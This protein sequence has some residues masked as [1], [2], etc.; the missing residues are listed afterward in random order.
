MP[1][2]VTRYNLLIS[3][4]SDV[5][6][7]IKIIR[8]TI[9]EYNKRDGDKNNTVI[10]T[11][12][13]SKDSYPQSGGRPQ[14]LLNQQFVL[15][16]DFVVAVFWTRFGTPTEKYGSGTEEE[17]EE[18]LKSGKQ[19][20]LYFSDQALSP[21]SYDPSQYRKVEKFR[22]KY[23]GRGIYATYKTLQEFEKQF[24]DH[25]KQYF[26]S[27]PHEKQ[28]IPM[29]AQ[30]Q[31]SIQG[32]NK[33]KPADQIKL[34][35]YDLLSL[36]FIEQAKE[37]IVSEFQKIKNIQLPV[38]TTKP[39]YQEPVVISERNKSLLC[40]YANKNNIE[41]NPDEFFYLGNLSEFENLGTFSLIGNV[42]EK[43]K[44]RRIH[45]LLTAI[46]KNQ[47]FINFFTK[48]DSKHFLSLCLSNHGTHPDE[49]IE[50]RLFVDKG[51]LC[52]KEE[53]PFPGIG[54]KNAMG[55][56]D[57]DEL[58]KNVY[59]EGKSL[60][61]KEYESENVNPTLLDD[62]F[63]YAVGKMM[64]TDSE[65]AE[66]H[67]K[68]YIEEINDI[69]IYDY[70]NEDS[71]DILIYTQNYIKH[72]TNIYLPSKLVF[73]SPP[74]NIRYEIRSKHSPNVITGEIKIEI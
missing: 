7:E 53:L 55:F 58:L 60:W 16:C 44:F 46:E 50:V 14:E 22:K 61:V 35:Q 72:N 37:D 43:A 38:Q 5:K 36:K 64:P 41:L 70:Y 66:I 68:N 65:E 30:A 57:M 74:D 6:D 34:Y 15:N 27:L 20:F 13:W 4:P 62:E 51:L 48:M 67:R 42:E 71:M 18:L 33:G 52:K 40:D 73:N 26:D 56:D 54:M 11:K 28:V 25:L 19:V 8:E 69:F 23:E 49:E 3:C 47:D 31:L 32:V 63:E 12:H 2:V 29:K 24:S 59:K 10:I 17:I 39:H 1:K 45:N 21:S 9:E